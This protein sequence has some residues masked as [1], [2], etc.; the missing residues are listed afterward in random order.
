VSSTA[1]PASNLPRSLAPLPTPPVVDPVAW[2]LA[3]AGGRRLV[4]VVDAVGDLDD[5]R[6]GLTRLIVARSRPLAR[7]SLGY[8]TRTLI[9]IRDE[10]AWWAAL[11]VCGFFF[12]HAPTSPYQVG[13]LA[14]A[15]RVARRARLGDFVLNPGIPVDP[16]YRDL[17]AT[18]C[19]FEGTW[20]QYRGRPADSF[21]PGDGHLVLDVPESDLSLARSMALARGAGLFLAT[22]ATSLFTD[23]VVLVTDPDE[24]TAPRQRT[25]NGPGYRNR[26]SRW[27]RPG[28]TART[29]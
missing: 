13:P 18:I 4:P 11:P 1:P 19:T 7:I 9:D 14:Q 2:A 29:R 15:I 22:G 12:D 10:I 24:V 23:P 27:D 28:L 17:P 3:A 25:G 5:L 26:P 6:A 16:I 21:V 20:T 8:G